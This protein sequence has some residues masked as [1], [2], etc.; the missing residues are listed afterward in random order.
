MASPDSHCLHLHPKDMILQGSATAF[1][2][3]QMV[4]WVRG[5]RCGAMLQ[6]DIEVQPGWRRQLFSP[7]LHWIHSYARCAYLACVEMQAHWEAPHCY[8]YRSSEHGNLYLHFQRIRKTHREISTRTGKNIRHGKFQE[9]NFPVL[10]LGFIYIWLVLYTVSLG[11]LSKK[12]NLTSLKK[13]K[14]KK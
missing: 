5:L 13:K 4:A 14:I 6:A 8:R 11:I 10:A 7:E 2:R 1:S 12:K 9:E 3:K